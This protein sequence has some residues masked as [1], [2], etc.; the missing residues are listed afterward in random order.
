MCACIAIT[1]ACRIEALPH[2][3]R[4]AAW[5]FLLNG[6]SQRFIDA[7]YLRLPKFVE[8]VMEGNNPEKLFCLMQGIHGPDDAY[9]VSACAPLVRCP[10]QVIGATEDRIAGMCEVRRLA[11]VISSSSLVEIAAGHLAPFE[12]PVLWRRRLMEH[13][14]RH[15]DQ[16]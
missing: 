12:E 4:S 15:E 13:F 10:T 14:D 2:D 16:R 9:S 6:Y 3:F 11:E 1:L 7:H 8:L 5:S